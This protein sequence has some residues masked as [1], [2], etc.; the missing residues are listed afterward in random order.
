MLGL[1]DATGL[2]IW[3]FRRVN[4]IPELL[5]AACSGILLIYIYNWIF[6]I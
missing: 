5:K 1:A 2:S 3:D 4:L 6:Y